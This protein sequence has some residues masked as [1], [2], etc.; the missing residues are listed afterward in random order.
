MVTVNI[1]SFL[2]PRVIGAVCLDKCGSGLGLQRA[3][4][5]GELL[6]TLNLESLREMFC[7]MQP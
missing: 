4:N 1:S 6:K 7:L 3:E 5:S 2:N